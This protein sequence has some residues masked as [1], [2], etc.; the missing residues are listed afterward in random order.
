MDK[1]KLNEETKKIND[2][3][4]DKLLDN[5][6]ANITNL[7]IGRADVKDKIRDDLTKILMLK[8]NSILVNDIKNIHENILVVIYYQSSISN[9]NLKK[10]ILDKL[11]NPILK[12]NIIHDISLSIINQWQS[13][14]YYYYVGSPLEEN[15]SEFDKKQIFKYCRAMDYNITRLL[16]ISHYKDKE[17]FGLIPIDVIKIIHNFVFPKAFQFVDYSE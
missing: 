7:H 17:L 3:H 4:I 11:N 5:V 12:M 10:T 8:N 15:L 6:V 14:Y 13:H 2:E 9:E 1:K 16:L